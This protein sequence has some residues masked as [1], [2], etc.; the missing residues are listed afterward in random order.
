MVS[1]AAIRTIPLILFIPILGLTQP[2][3]A[4]PPAGRNTLFVV[5]DGA[6][7]PKHVLS[8]VSVSEDRKWKAYVE[9]DVQGGS[10]CMHTTR[11]WVSEAGGPNR[12]VYLMAPKRTAVGNGMEILG[13][14]KGSR[15]LLVKTEEW[16]QGSDAADTQQV[17]AIDAGTGMVYEPALD[18]MLQP[19]KGKQCSFRVDN[20]GFSADKNINIL[21]RAHFYTAMDVDQTEADIPAAKRCDHVEETWSFNFATGQIGKVTNTSH[22]QLFSQSPVNPV[23]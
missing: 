6:D 23:N 9:V 13:W 12:I 20:A 7:G 1:S 15:M 2:T 22:L 10:G 18:A 4:T 5:C 8:P 11:L 3:A 19:R 14:G 17:L 21:V 16:Q